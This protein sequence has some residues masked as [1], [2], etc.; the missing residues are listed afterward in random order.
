LSV[1]T[2]TA[3]YEERT[4]WNLCKLNKWNKYPQRT[5]SEPPCYRS[6][7]TLC[8]IRAWKQQ[9]CSYIVTKTGFGVCK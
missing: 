4:V 1:I 5:V 2:L 7:I 3:G 6:A 9:T 8:N